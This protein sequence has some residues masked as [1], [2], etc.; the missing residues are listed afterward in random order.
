M[1]KL[2]PLL[3]LLAVPALAQ[4]PTYVS[5]ATLAYAWDM[6]G[7]A[8]DPNQIVTAVA[9]EDDKDDY[10]IAAQPDICRLVDTTIVDTD[11]SVGTLTITGLGCLGEAR[12]CSFAFT[13]GDDTGVQTLT[14]TDAEG[15]YFASVTKAETDTMTG[16][17]DETFALGYTSNSVNGWPMYGKKT[18][19][20]NG[21]YGVDPFGSLEVGLRVTTSGASSTTVTGVT[22]AEDAFARPSAGDIVIFTIGGVPYERSIVTNA[23]ADTITINTAINIPAAGITYRYKPFWYSSNPD[24]RMLIPVHGHRTAMIDWS[25]DANVNTGGV[26]TLLEC[27]GEPGPGWPLEN[28]VEL[29]TT[30]VASTSTQAPTSESVNVE[31]LPYTYCRFGW[32]FGT[33]DDGDGADEDI[34]TTISLMR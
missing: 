14:C 1:R 9:M 33:G 6:D 8:A 27:V 29:D 24:H 5:R 21:E 15:A 10:T 18:I 7:E 4:T 3:V 16:E 32:S 13:A 2:I 26:I 19:G 28:W 22:A 20:P 23:D 34:N 12:V 30:T 31:L 17:S 11:L 25:V